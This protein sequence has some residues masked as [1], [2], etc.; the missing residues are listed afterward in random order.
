MGVLLN[1]DDVL[2]VIFYSYSFEQLG[3]NV[4]HYTVGPPTGEFTDKMLAEALAEDVKLLYAPVMASSALFIGVSAE[5]VTPNPKPISYSPRVDYAGTLTGDPLPLETAGLI[6]LRSEQTGPG[7]RGRMYIPFPAVSAMEEDGH[8]T[9]AYTDDLDLLGAWM[10]DSHALTVD[11]NGI[12]VFPV[13]RSTT[14]SGY[15]LVN[16]YIVRRLWASSR[17]RGDFAKR[18]IPPF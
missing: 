11:I 13:L 12:E 9:Q 15:P 1:E 14:P 16:D 6:S 18:N 17:R 5:R 10:K 2:R 3:M 8:P 7:G 4:R